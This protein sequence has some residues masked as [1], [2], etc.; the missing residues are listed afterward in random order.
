MSVLTLTF[1]SC[2]NKSNTPSTDTKNADTITV[3]TDSVAIDN[4]SISKVEIDTINK[5]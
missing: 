4:D 3:K 2:G 5:E 1:M